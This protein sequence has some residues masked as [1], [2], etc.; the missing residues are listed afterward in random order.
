MKKSS[1]CIAVHSVSAVCQRCLVSRLTS[2]RIGSR[3]A[4]HAAA[5]T[6]SR[7]A[8]FKWLELFRSALC[9]MNIISNSRYRLSRRFISRDNYRYGFMAQPSSGVTH[10]QEVE[11][12]H[13][14]DAQS[15]ELQD[16]R[17]QIRALHLRN[18][19]VG[20]H[21]KVLLWQRETHKQTTTFTKYT[22]QYTIL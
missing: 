11:A 14:V 20:Q 2:E 6:L 5:S 4:H 10:R 9:L 7:A 1:D 12:Q 15:F 21:L 8:R 17:S 13:I 16:D 3:E 22:V 19:R 18:R